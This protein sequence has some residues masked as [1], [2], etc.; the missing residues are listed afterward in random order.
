MT[1]AILQSADPF[2][3]SPLSDIELLKN[4]NAKLTLDYFAGIVKPNAICHS[5]W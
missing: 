4:M 5:R 2:F 1:H 3:S